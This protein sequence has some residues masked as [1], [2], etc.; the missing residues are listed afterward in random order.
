MLSSVLRSETAIKVNIEI[1]RA[2]VKMKY[3]ETENHAVWQ[4]NFLV[5]L[6]PS[7]KLWPVNRQ[8]I[9]EKSKRQASE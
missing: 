8:I 7:D 6:K 3:A 1:M 9:I 5:Y 4:K 2:F